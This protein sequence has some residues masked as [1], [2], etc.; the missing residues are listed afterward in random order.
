[1]EILNQNLVDNKNNN[2]KVKY[3][4][5]P[6]GEINKIKEEDTSSEYKKIKIYK[7]PDKENYEKKENNNEFLKELINIEKKY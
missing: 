2:K 6:N 7:I 4:K 1:M 5:T 3:Y